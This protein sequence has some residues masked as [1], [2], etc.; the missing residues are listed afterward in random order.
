VL[1]AP[2][3]LDL[4]T[5]RRNGS[6]VFITVWSHTFNVVDV[7]LRDGRIIKV[8]QAWDAEDVRAAQESVAI[9]A[10]LWLKANP[11]FKSLLLKVFAF[12]LV[13]KV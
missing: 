6:H 2:W 10:F 12:R 5:R 11:T 9:Y 1:F 8:L 3:G 4:T 7:A 13:V